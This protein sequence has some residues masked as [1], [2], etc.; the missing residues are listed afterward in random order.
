VAS[1]TISKRKMVLKLA[2]SSESKCTSKRCSVWGSTIHRVRSDTKSSAAGAASSA[3]GSSGR[4]S[5]DG[6]REP[7]G[8]TGVR[9]EKF[10]GGA[11]SGR[12]CGNGTN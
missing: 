8:G 11:R 1:P 3:A 2:T 5:L 12:S 9:I 10:A 4:A 6:C 7:S